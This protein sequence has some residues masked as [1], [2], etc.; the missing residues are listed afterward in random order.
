MLILKEML[1]CG[2][3]TSLS[4]RASFWSLGH[5][6]YLKQMY[7]A[8]TTGHVRPFWK[9]KVR[10]KLVLNQMASSYTPVHPIVFHLF[11]RSKHKGKEFAK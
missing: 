11:I 2:E 4:L 7:N 5:S 8:C 9:N 1:I 6:K 3:V 10:P